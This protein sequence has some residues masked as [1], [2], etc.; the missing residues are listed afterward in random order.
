MSKDP[1]ADSISNLIPEQSQ[2]AAFAAECNLSG[3]SLSAVGRPTTAAK[4]G[5]FLAEIFRAAS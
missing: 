1:A 5:R 4:T 2:R 3:S